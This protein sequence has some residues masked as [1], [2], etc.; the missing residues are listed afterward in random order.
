MVRKLICNRPEPE[1]FTLDCPTQQVL[2]Q[3][4]DIIGNKLSIYN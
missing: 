1:I 2:E 4:L 3:V